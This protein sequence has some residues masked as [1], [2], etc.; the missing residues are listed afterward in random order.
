MLGGYTTQHLNYA[1][2][3]KVRDT[4][5]VIFNLSQR[6]KFPVVKAQNAVRLTQQHIICFGDDL[7][8]A[9]ACNETPC[10]SSFPCDYS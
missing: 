2:P 3:N 7:V 9:D 5:S 10:E 4:G 1:Q 8:I 6:R